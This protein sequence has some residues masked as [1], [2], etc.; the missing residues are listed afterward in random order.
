MSALFSMGSLYLLLLIVG[1]IGFFMH[2]YAQWRFARVLRARY[3]RKWD[4]IAHPDQGSKGGL[5][6]WGRLQH[7]LRS[8]VPDLF[9]DEELHHWHR[10]W[11]YAPWLA[12]PCWIGVLVIQAAVQ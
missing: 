2:L 11:R 5:H 8:K 9:E 1:A 10:V 7:V 3:P 4:I 12:W 6:T